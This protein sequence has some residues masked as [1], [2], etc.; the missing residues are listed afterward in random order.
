MDTDFLFGSLRFGNELHVKYCL[1]KWRPLTSSTVD[2]NQNILVPGNTS[3]CQTQFLLVFKIRN[4]P[5]TP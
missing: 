2:E 5:W 1:R 4:R 3:L